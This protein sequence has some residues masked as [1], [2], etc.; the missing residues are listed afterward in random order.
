[1][2]EN[3]VKFYRLG[4]NN[5][6]TLQTYNQ[7]ATGNNIVFAK[8]AEGEGTW[9]ATDNTLSMPTYRIFAGGIHYNVAD[10]DALN[11]VMDQVNTW[12]GDVNV[13]GSILNIIANAVNAA[14]IVALV[15]ATSSN[16]SAEVVEVTD[17]KGNKQEKIK[18][19]AATST[20]IKTGSAAP[21]D[22]G[23]TNPKNGDYYI[24]EVTIN[25]SDVPSRTAY[26]YNGETS[27]WQALDGNVTAENVYFPDGLQ[28]TAQFGF[29]EPSMDIQTECVGKN[30]K[31]LLEWY[32]V[33]E[34]YPVVTLTQATANAGSYNITLDTPSNITTYMEGLANNS[35]V[36]VGTS[37]KFKGIELTETADHTGNKTGGYTGTAGSITGMKYNYKKDAVDGD[38]VEQKSYT[39]NIPRTNASYTTNFDT[40]KVQMALTNA[41]GFTG[42]TTAN[43]SCGVNNGTAALSEQS[44]TTVEGTNTLKLSWTNDASV[45]RTLTDQEGV[46]AY[47]AYP[48]SNKG[49]ASTNVK[50]TV[51]AT[52]WSHTANAKSKTYTT[53]TYTLNAVYPIYTNGVTVTT[54]Y[55][56]ADCKWSTN[57]FN[58]ADTAGGETR[59]VK[60]E[61]LA[62]YN[63]KSKKDTEYYI[64]AGNQGGVNPLMIYIP[65]SAGITKLTAASYD[66]NNGQWT[67]FTCEL[68]H[69]IDNDVYINGVKYHVW[70][71]VSS[72]GPQNILVT[73]A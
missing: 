14:Q 68:T 24:Q 37:V 11:Y 38:L 3:N 48:L 66:V 40:A 39:S 54:T 16:V 18:L 23:I 57:S 2:A 19:T 71:G 1:M 10:A 32:L 53:T 29:Q 47:T 41:G 46:S 56:E 33:E 42:I 67:G 52:S 7:Y 15:D 45:S 20:V 25:G 30:L 69:S 58:I 49:N 36:E 13:E 26:I 4:F 61:K 73:F 27:T 63:Y 31:D 12:K 17:S 60:G 34:K 35:L 22:A 9:D 50:Y 64:G 70:S 65:E 6:V 43:T 5:P 28:R 59:V 44:G 51:N 72:Y 8:V 62:L 21:E 55:V